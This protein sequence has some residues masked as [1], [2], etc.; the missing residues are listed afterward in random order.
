VV[1]GHRVDEAVRADLARVLVADRHARAQAGTDDGD[2]VAE[3]ALAHRHPLR[4]QLRHRRGHDRGVHVLEGEAAQREQ[5]AQGG[6]QLVAGRVAH[7]R[8]APVLHELLAAERAHVGLRVA[9]V[10]D[11]E[12][13]RH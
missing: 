12:H 2:V 9:G 3:V 5:A 1:A 6:R 4:P 10:D 8:E 13:G 7:G 11:E